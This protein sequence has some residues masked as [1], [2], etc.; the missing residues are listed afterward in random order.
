MS[1]RKTKKLMKIAEAE[2]KIK[3]S[4]EVHSVSE[5]ENFPFGSY[6]EVQE[7]YRQGRLHVGCRINE[8]VV[9]NFGTIGQQVMEKVLLSSPVIAILASIAVAIARSQ[10]TLLWGIPLALLGMFMTTPAIMRSGQGF[11]GTVL[12]VTFLTFGYYCFKAN[13]VPAFL[14]GSYWVP[15]FLLTVSREQNRMVMTDAIMKSEL[16]FLYYLQQGDIHVA[17]K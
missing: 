17:R 4:L 9:D 13:F 14:L 11:G 1:H 7:L 16:V 5:V 12:G 2:A 10:Y 8:N 15:N 3:G 6:A